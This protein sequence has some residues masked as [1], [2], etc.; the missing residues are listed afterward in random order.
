MKKLLS[1]LL[2]LTL[3]L[4]AGN[5][6]TL[7]EDVTEFER[8]SLPKSAL[9]KVE[10]I[11]K[12]AKEDKNEQQFIKALLHKKNYLLTLS[13]DG[14]VK[15]IQDLENSIKE[16]P[17]KHTRFIL[18]SILAEM[19]AK[20]LDR[21]YYKIRNRSTLKKDRSEDITT[22]SMEKLMKKSSQLYLTSLDKRTQKVN[23]EHYKMIMSEQKNTEGLMPT[24]YD[25]LASRALK[26]FKNERHY[27]NKAESDFTITDKD[28]FGSAYTFMYNHFRAENKNSFKYQVLLI[29][30]KLLQLHSSNGQK[31][32]LSHANLERLSFV[33]H[34]FN[35]QKSKKHY[36][37][38]L[39]Q[40]VKKNPQSEALATLAQYYFLEEEYSKALF[41]A[42]KG[43][44]SSN[45]Y[46]IYLCTNIKNNLEQKS[47]QFEMEQVNLPDENI[48]SKISY[49]NGSKVFIKVVKATKEELTALEKTN[50]KEKMNYL[51]NLQAFK[52]FDFNLPTYSD[53]KQHSTEISLG[54]YGLGEYIFMLSTDGTF[55]EHSIYKI[56]TISNL[57]YFI[58][59]NDRV[60]M[61]H[62]KTGKPLSDVKASFYGQHYN[63]QT[64][65][66]E[67][68]FH[69]S[70]NS[71]KNGFIALPKIKNTR[72]NMI[73]TYKKDKLK[74]NGHLYGSHYEQDRGNRSHKFVN[75]FTD[76][77]IY[78]PNQTIYFKGLAI[79][80]NSHNAP[81]V[82]RDKK[83]VIKFYNTNHQ[84]IEEK[85]F[86]TDD[87]GTF[88]GTFTAPKSGLL[89]AMS[90]RADMGGQKQIQVEEY[91][92]PKFEVT[93]NELEKSYR[94]GDKILLKGEAKA[95]A[96]N[97]LDGATVKYRV[98]RT[99]SFPWLYYW[100]TKPYSG[101]RHITSGTTKTDSKGIFKID[102]KA[103]IDKSLSKEDKANY[104]YRVSV[105]V[106][107]STG[108]SHSNSKTIT[109]GYVAIA[110]NMSIKKEL[111]RDKN[112]TLTLET[113]NLYGNFQALKGEVIIEKL[114]ED[115]KIYRKRYWKP[116]E[117][118]LYS[119]EEFNK[120]FKQYK[121]AN[122]EKK[123]KSTTIKTI[124][125]NTQKS[126][127]IQLNLLEQGAYRVTL[128][129]A[130]RY[131]VKV[132]KEKK[133]T[134]YNTKAKTAPTT[135][136]LWQKSDKK[137]YD[138]DTQA[139]LTLK[140]SVKK[141]PLLLSIER[142]GKL[143]QEKWVTVDGVQE[144]LIKITKEDQGN[145]NYHLNFIQENRAYS[146][147]GTLSI[148]WNNK[149]KIEFLSFRDKLKPNEKEQWKIKI[150][151]KDKEKIMAQMVAT[152]YDAS[153][154]D[155]KPHRFNLNSLFPFYRASYRVWDSRNFNSISDQHSW[156]KNEKKYIA[157]VFPTLKW[158]HQT[159]GYNSFGRSGNMMYESEAMVEASPVV[160]P[161][162]M[163]KS[164]MIS[165]DMSASDYRSKVKE[166]G[167]PVA[168]VS[169]NTMESKAVKKSKPLHIRKN[170]NETMFFKPNLQTDKEGNIIIDF[171]TNEALTR[172][173]FL[174]FAHTK[175]LKTA[176]T[177]KILTTSKEL[178][179]VSNLPRFFR[180]KDTI[181]LSAKVVNMSKKDLKGECELQLVD[182]LTEKPIYD[183]TFKKSFHIKKGA[184]TIVNFSIKIPDID[185]V[186]AIKH[187]LIARTSTHSDAEQVIK[188]I[189][190]NR[191]FITESKVL[192]IKANAE[193]M[194][195]LESLKNSN[196]TTLKNH[197]LTLEF[198]SNPAWYAIQ[199]LPYL[200]EYEHECSEQLFSRYYANALA[201]NI[202]NSSPKIK[203]I[204]DEWREKGTP[205]SKLSTN[206]ELKSILLEETPWVLENQSQEQ[207]QKNIALLFDLHKVASEQ[208]E[209]L[210]K[211]KERQLSSGGWSWFGGGRASWYITQYIVEGMG[212]LKTLGVTT[213]ED[214]MISSA[215]KFMD[216]Q[217]VQEYNILQKQVEEGYRKLEDDN[218]N[219]M[220]THYLYARSFYKQ[221]MSKE[222]KTAHNYYLKQAQKYWLNKGLYEQGMIAL[223]LHREK[224][225]TKDIIASLK[226]HALHSDEFGMYFKYT[227]GYY[228]NELPI[229][230]HTLM[231]EVFDTVA[232]DKKS[233]EALKTWL[234][235]QRQ[236]T[237]WK[238]TKAT[239]S[240]IY[241]LLSNNNWLENDKLVDVSFKTQKGYQSKLNE[242]QSKAIKGLGYYKVTYNKEEFDQSMA[243]LRVTNP[244]NNIAWGGM[245]WQYF[246][247]MDKVKTFK[248]TPLTIDKK[249]FLI[250][251]SKNGEQLSPIKN[252]ALK[253]GD[254][255]KVRIVIKVDRNMEYIMLKDSR[256]SAFEPLTVISSYKYQD[257]LGYYQSTK[258][259]ATY[260]FMD[261][262]K[263]GT[264]VFEYPLVVTHKG[265]FSNGITSMESMYAPEF[266]SHSEGVRVKVR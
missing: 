95:F 21:N 7:W 72:Y 257:G 224:L 109:L 129:T 258:D 93:F 250:E 155:L 24:L 195:T 199:S 218:L 187:T 78:R 163:V 232:K 179:V 231:I 200:M 162:P 191:V 123:Q 194:F 58:K 33:Y 4:S 23:I 205:K 6:E 149:L 246:E 114:I 143:S 253:V 198:T 183:K 216:S 12:Q 9:A 121:Y 22:W 91:K 41:Y 16:S 135:T 169:V 87:F 196:S 70:K 10:S 44:K 220:L 134:I 170:F 197:K 54:S 42:N 229:E 159:H 52:E 225:E 144:E 110:V 38:A 166:E 85:T 249:L 11:Y 161:A 236:T 256:A 18:T 125:F 173:K 59:E 214:A 182:P 127:T 184:S 77:A 188:P 89:G 153:L 102:F 138:I 207:Q 154:D 211:L 190:S 204:F 208:K 244:N 17:K 126:K 176:I 67:K 2:L 105:D 252:Q 130:D 68:K 147:R 141:L 5:Y 219:S 15:A 228:W 26:H 112:Q 241:A 28:A 90:L 32:A 76:R 167:L 181:T 156:Q 106:I 62:R 213:K 131:G 61:V 101:L 202:A 64:R 215:I 37:T 172:W 29:Y 165:K 242:A 86:T 160:A 177:S 212:H 206:A 262:L 150:S 30:Q 119:Q 210:N 227:N 81:K 175:D 39:K 48:L 209:A 221:S 266:K 136:Y 118:S 192:S 128:K 137:S 122:K 151:G 234:L 111:S 82:L 88:H 8:K 27:L 255:V 104:S 79:Q 139:L 239:S 120:L 60:L 43:L 108:E 3:F 157:R 168:G 56:A 260:F 75:F 20:Y 265:E 69:S 248:E 238:T 247:E 113:T 226:E 107:D 148:P 235:K 222:T 174:A 63:H 152:M 96:G 83:V 178:M 98:E 65:E 243:T 51:N 146:Q 263:R 133:I 14:H 53:Y 74:H 158:L 180:E 57:A 84:V 103:L 145:I 259:N 140:S 230:T 92:R 217:L 116:V 189:L 124:P 35:A 245:Y 264:Y 73:L 46:L 1:I 186:S 71:D 19:Y 237:H 97:A 49:R 40:L 115:T 233:V 240:A 203:A 55:D 164:F 171:K 142:Q 31:R 13:Q 66:E 80:R 193:K 36:L 223:A 25:F 185:K 261:Y 201:E 100:Q 47:L 50:Y 34:N 99:A 117:K 254:K 45:D 94:L 132:S 251:Q